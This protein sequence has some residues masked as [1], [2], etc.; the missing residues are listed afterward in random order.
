MSLL[1]HQDHSQSN[2]LR[3][4]LITIGTFERHEWRQI[5]VYTICDTISGS[6][7]QFHAMPFPH[8]QYGSL[9]VVE[10]RKGVKNKPDN[11]RKMTLK[12]LKNKP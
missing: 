11:A 2:L 10:I 9:R 5:K 3:E 12:T 7:F 6:V 1:K 8:W 4:S